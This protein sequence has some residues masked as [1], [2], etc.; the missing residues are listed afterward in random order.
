MLHCKDTL[1]PQHHD[2]AQDRA[3]QSAATLG[4]WQSEKTRMG[5]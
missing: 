3:L 1:P 2:A 4:T 5:I